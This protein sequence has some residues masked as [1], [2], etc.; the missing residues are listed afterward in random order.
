MFR[1]SI[2]DETQMTSD[3]ILEGLY[4]LRKAWN[5]AKNIFKLREEDKAA[6]HFSAEEWVLPAA[7]TEEPEERKFV[8]DSGASMHMVSKGDLNPAELETVRTLRCPT[9]VMTANCEVQTRE[10][11]RVYVKQSDLFVKVML[12]EETP[13]VLSLGNL[14]EDHGHTYHW[15]S[16]QKPHLIRN[17]KRIDCNISNY[18]PFVVFGLSASSSSTTLS[19]TSPSSSSQDSVFDVNRNTKN[20]VQERGGST[21]EELRGDPLHESTETE[22]IKMVSAKT[23]KEIDRMS[24]LIGYRNSGRIYLMKVLQQSLGET[25]SREVKTLPSHL[26]NFQWSRKQKWNRDR[27][28]TV[29][30]PTF[31]RTQI[32]ISA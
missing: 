17:G 7:S 20:P 15:I 29:Y 3:D 21:S 13:V 23:Y 24:C 4:K 16:G 6:F 19:P 22:K 9:T 26:M 31:R 5:L 11:A 12:L 2:R 10:E 18:V 25:Q 14:C 32:V 30:K 27:G 28:S 8:V 1:N